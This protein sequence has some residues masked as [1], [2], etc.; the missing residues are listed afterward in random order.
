MVSLNLSGLTKTDI[1]MVLGSWESIN[2]D[3]ASSIFYRELFNTY[4]DTKSLFVKFYSV[5]ND[6]LID[7]PAALKQLRVT[8]TAIT[9]LIDYLKK[10]RIDEANKAIDYLIEKHRKIKTFQGPMFNMALEPLLYLVK[11]KL[12]SQAYIDAYKKVF[13]A[14]FLTIISKY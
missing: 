8:W 3:E 7:N 6:K 9:T 2:N 14:I 1:N 13:G 4:P 10:G 12:T 5:D 11:E